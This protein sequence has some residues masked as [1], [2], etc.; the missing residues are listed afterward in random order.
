LA[1]IA[2]AVVGLSL[3]LPVGLV[4]AAA[5]YATMGRP[6]F[7]TQER[8]G[9]GGRPF[10]LVKFRTM[11]NATGSNGGL[12]P[13]EKRITVLG[14]V[15]RRLRIDEL[16][17]LWNILKGDMSFIGPRPLLP[18]SPPNL[19]A[20]GRLRLS[21]RPGLTGW[22]QVN[23]NTLLDDDM[24]LSLDLWYVE[25]RSWLLDL[26]ILVKTA[27]VALFGERINNAR[28]AR[29]NESSRRRSG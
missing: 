23:G 14:K 4:V 24:K 25:N 10:V 29:A 1:D 15:L 6:I 21:V 8:A 9:R 26:K 13:D 2:G 16:P 22:A 20:G 7:F 18:T 12:L 5:I 28:L 11:T 3:L 27:G 17:E 19:G